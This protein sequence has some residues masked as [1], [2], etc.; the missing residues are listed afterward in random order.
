MNYKPDHQELMAY[1]YDELDSQAKARVEQYLLEN[2]AVREELEG[3][4]GVSN[5]LG[6]VKDKEVIA[7]PL[8]LPEQKQRFWDAPYFKTVVS[9]AASLI[10]VI[11]V[12]RFSGTS[13]SVSGNEVRL[14]FGSAAPAPVVDG[15][16]DLTP[17]QVQAMINQSLQANNTQLNSTWEESQ[18]RLEKS[19]RSNLVSN[20]VKI[21]ELVQQ[22]SSASKD[23]I[24]QYVSSMQQEN[25]K[26]VKDY[27]TLSNGEQKQYI[28]GLLVDFAK[29]LQ[30][31]R[32]DDLQL[33][34]MRINTLEKSTNVLKQETE[35]ILTSIISGSSAPVG[36]SETKY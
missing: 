5:L 8:F 16:A 24:Q 1:L 11:L 34:Q 27:F 7:P 12:A 18:Q 30:Q 31:Q 29:Y 26:M 6:N 13:L 35:Q 15:K 33:V 2:P 3:L 10:F 17:N 25:V 19:I 32:K 4:A 28:E 22:V 23:Q 21:D 14:S 9:I 20:N 36:N